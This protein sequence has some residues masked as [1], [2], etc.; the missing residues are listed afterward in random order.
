MKKILD[1]ILIF[2]L[3]F[4]IINFFNNKKETEQIP[5]QVIFKTLK[6]SYSIPADV[7]LSITNNTSKDLQ[8]NTCNNIEITNPNKEPIEIDKD[9]CKNI[10][11]NSWE[12][13]II[14]Y[15]VM[16]NKFS[17]IWV[18]TF[19]LLIDDKEYISQS[20]IEN[21]WFIWKLFVWVVY[22][23][24]YNLMIFLLGLFW[25]SL[26]WAIIVITIIIRLIL[27]WPQH[28]MMLSQKK[29]QALQ[30]KIKHIQKKYKWNQQQ[31][32]MKMMELYK[33]EKVN[34]MWSCWFMFIQ[35]PILL[36]MYRII[37]NIKDPSNTYY[38]YNSLSNF[39]ISKINYDFY[40]IDLL[41]KWGLVWLALALF[42]WIIQFIQVKLSMNLKNK[43]SCKDKIVLEKKKWQDSY[44]SMMPDPDTMNKVML[45][46]MPVMITFITY[47]LFAGVWLYWWMS[48]I[49]AIVQQII[50][51]KIFKKSS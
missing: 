6:T 15:S 12:E 27:I 22:K 26:W 40:W 9:L 38:I 31:L 13:E 20:T 19:K 10:L 33:K 45:Y 43:Q 44:N 35:M 51:N 32:W 11:L 41:G 49:F 16:F 14:D 5:Q 24:I 34:P 4:F 30:P 25:Y 29:L 7:K 21:R 18:Y 47:S 46:W 17:D 39:D 3:I 42:I 48:T 37:L 36:V 8:L 2:L 50:V 23:P 1:Y 28:K